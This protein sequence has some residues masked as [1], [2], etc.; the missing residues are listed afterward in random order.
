MIQAGLKRT[1]VVFVAALSCAMWGTG[2]EETAPPFIPPS[3]TGSFES[4]ET[5]DVLT[6]ESE[7]LTLEVQRSRPGFRRSRTRSCEARRLSLTRSMI[8]GTRTLEISCDQ[9]PE[10]AGITLTQRD[11]VRLSAR[12]RLSAGGRHVISY[13]DLERIR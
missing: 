6:I 3:Y 2:C 11:D 10:E 12:I 1:C 7:V 4:F 5:G 13:D 9:W 8:T